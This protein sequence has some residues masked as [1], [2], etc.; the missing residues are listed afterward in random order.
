[1]GTDKLYQEIYAWNQYPQGQ[2]PWNQKLDQ[3]EKMVV[4]TLHMEKRK[5]EKEVITLGVEKS[6]IEREVLTLGSERSKYEK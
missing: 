3:G 4:P 2:L 1:M 6:I 5:M